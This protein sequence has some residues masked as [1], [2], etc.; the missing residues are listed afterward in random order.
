MKQ[1]N[2]TSQIPDPISR[3]QFGIIADDLTSA[4]DA[5]MAFLGKRRSPQILRSFEQAGMADVVAI[6]TDSR[7]QDI[8]TAVA[9]TR[10]SVELLRHRDILLKTID[11]TLRGHAKAEIAAA[12]RASGRK[13]LVIAPAFPAAGRTTRHG[14]QYVSG[15]RVDESHYAADPIHP[16]RTARIADL[17]DSICGPVRICSGADGLHSDARVLILDAARQSELDAHVRRI[18]DLSQV[19]WVGSPGLATALA[20]LL[21]QA[22]HPV[23]PP[24]PAKRLLIV[25][26][27]ANP[28]T[29]AQCD[30]LAKAGI[31]V[32]TNPA[33][34]P[35]EPVLCLTVPRQ[36]LASPPLTAVVKQAADWLRSGRFDAV[37]AT[38]GETMAAILAQLGIDR[39]HLTGEIEPGFPIGSAIHAGRTLVLAMKAGGFG[40]SDTLL[41]AARTLYHEK[42]HHHD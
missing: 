17:V 14:I 31:P 11:S 34:A 18:E 1:T 30:Y 25:A 2:K 15:L 20:G 35:D 37:V 21:P 13:F 23:T 19:L 28:V 16:V 41:R 40:K 24:K 26:G 6:D 42:D 38:G 3:A 32:F 27:S 7:A 22:A 33:T 10:E 5:A 39:F 36:R 4:A 8:A 9:R 12:F 29:H